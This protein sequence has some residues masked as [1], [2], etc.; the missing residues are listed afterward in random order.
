[1]KQTTTFAASALVLL[2]ATLISTS[3]QTASATTALARPH[4]RAV[5]DVSTFMS[6]VFGRNSAEKTSAYAYLDFAQDVAIDPTSGD[7]FIADT[8]NSMIKRMT[9]STSML[10]K[11][12]GSGSYGDSLGLA[13][14]A[15]FAEPKGIAVAS[16]GT[17]YIADTGN[18]KI[19]KS[20]TARG[21]V[22]LFASGLNKPEGVLATASRLFI[23]D[24]GNNAIK[25]MYRSGAGAGIM[26]T[27]ASGGLLSGPRKMAISGN[28]KTLYVT[29]TGAHKVVAI[30]IATGAQTL[31]AGSGSNAYAEG[32]GAAASFQTVWGIARDGDS[33][34]VT[35]GN[36]FTDKLRKI[37][38]ATGTTSLV[39]SDKTMTSLN[40]PAGITLDA[41]NIYVANSGLGT[42]Y[43]FGKSAPTTDQG[44]Y[45][46]SDRFENND[47]DAPAANVGRPWALA[48]ASSDD[49][50]MYVAENNKLSEV[51]LPTATRT[52]IWGNSIDNYKDA[53][54]STGRAS[55]ISSLAVDSTRSTIYFTDTWNN[56]IRKVDIA[57]RTSSFVSG[58][59]NTNVTGSGNGYAEGSATSAKFDNPRGIAIS[60]DNSTLYVVDTSNARIRKVSTSDGSTSFLAG[61]SA[62]YTNGTGAAAKFNRPMGVAVDS[63]N[64]YLYV[65]DSYNSAIR[66]V[67][68]SDGKVETFA[69]AGRSGYRDAIGTAAFFSIPE[70]VA[71]SGSYLYVSEAGGNKIRRI[72]I[73]TRA[74]TTVAGTEGIKGYRNGVG[75]LARFN[76]PK[77]LLVVGK[78]LYVADSKNDLIR[79]IILAL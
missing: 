42:I 4:I 60:P 75:A 40:F 31:I 35:D 55:T 56:R 27:L 28:G 53:T 6:S 49:N 54:G 33:L 15:Q 67:R 17:I 23:A 68:I 39:A 63:T 50:C 66:R 11:F 7:F 57:T 3:P 13:P 61:S 14:S 41:S 34:Y 38:I 65:A 77:G 48:K 1:M 2:A 16:D 59:G 58:S 19:K 69:G 62:G 73:A 8:N 45:I 52:A 37:N 10:S 71:I 76:D 30:T 24:T 78:N 64:T 51:Y 18:N 29:S 44:I 26:H 32:T 43:R 72:N 12:L 9:A 74:V 21:P 36:G 46:G 22:T 20:T 5:G 25:W 70:Y 79:K 47:G